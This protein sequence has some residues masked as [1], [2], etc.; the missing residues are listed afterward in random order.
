MRRSSALRRR[1]GAL[2]IRWRLVLAATALLPIALAGLFA[3]IFL[4]FESALNSSID[5]DLQSRAAVLATTIDRQ[6]IEAV[7]GRSARTLL[8]PQG[9]FAQI[10]D[11]GGRIRATSPE[12]ATVPLLTPEQA[13]GAVSRRYEG[14]RGPIPGLAKRSRLVAIPLRSE[15]LT[16]VVGRSLKGRE[17][18]NES[19]ARALLIGGPLALLIA[20]AA[21]WFAAGAALRPVEEMRAR[22]EELSADK[23]D[24]RLPVPVADDEIGRLGST[25]N[26]MLAR[27]EAAN[28]RQRELVQN[29][30]HELRTPIATLLA[31]LELAARLDDP[32]AV[33]GAIEVAREQAERVSRLADDLLVLARLDEHGAPIRRSPQD[34][35]ELVHATAQRFA[36][37]A[38]LSGRDLLL[39]GEPMVASVDPARFEQALGNLTD[40]ALRHGRGRIT[41]GW[42]QQDGSLV[43][44]VRDE[45]SGIPPALRSSA[46]DRFVRGET[47]ADGSGLGLAIVAAIAQAHGGSAEVGA[48]GAVVVRLCAT[49]T[50]A[51]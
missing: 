5:A 4:R 15:H 9:A 17:G 45:G 23:P 46:F 19:F 10:L 31:E 50:P 20:A 18:A 36:D 37:P 1:I 47:A 13:A 35:G 28:A 51:V 24:A 8:A 14:D 49:R 16:L 30:S 34:I 40:N 44:T 38:R 39:D 48:D 32:A 27:L 7:S 41:I 29:A 42:H 25:L 3:L 33:S 43:L 6:G 11:G 21:C 22:A 26:A 2:P 12:V